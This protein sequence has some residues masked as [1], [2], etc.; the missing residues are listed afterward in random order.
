MCENF[1]YIFNYNLNVS[2]SF[3]LL[4]LYFFVV[5]SD[6]KLGII[7][8][9][10]ASYFLPVLMR[11]IYGIERT[12]PDRN[13]LAALPDV[14][15]FVLVFVFFIRILCRKQKFIQ[16]NFDKYI[17]VFIA[18]NILQIFN[19]YKS[20]GVGMYG[21]RSVLLPMG[22]YFV[23]REFFTSKED[24]KKFLY[25]ILACSIIDM[26]Y[27][28]YQCF[29]GFTPFDT[30][31][32]KD[33]PDVRRVMIWE[34]FG[35]YEGFNK[36]FSVSGGSYNLF[37]PL[38]FFA[39]LLMN[40]RS[41]SFRGGYGIIKCIFVLSFVV[42]LTFGRERTPI[43]M[44]LIGIVLSNLE[45]NSAK[46][47]LKRLIV[48]GVIIGSIAISLH[49]LKQPLIRTGKYEYYRLAELGTPLEARTMKS[50]RI[51]QWE[52]ALDTIGS[53]VL[54]GTGLGTGTETTQTMRESALIVTP[55]NWYLKVALETGL[56][57]FILFIVLLFRMFI[58][59]IQHLRRMGDQLYH[60][61]VKG[62]LAATAAILVMGFANI[63]LEY[64]LGIFFWFLVGLVSFLSTLANEQP[65]VPEHD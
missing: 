26:V 27:G 5:L 45:F 49:F 17:L 59:F 19:P 34:D 9:L 54:F 63:P 40:I 6:F 4:F 41:R 39:L 12:L 47:F 37:Y 57:G 58:L 28:L 18:W 42:L 61:L 55:H 53:H 14:F 10:I 60:G 64:H 25:V 21:A 13:L 11:V 56:I 16:I 2:L 3:G 30:A 35:G 20:L 22:M 23:A 24:V 46:K 43:A 65:G 32:I 62:M 8:F 7:L 31:Y 36:I 15:L 44:L 51:I 1:L 50:R 33:F 48:S 29:F 52:K 38:A